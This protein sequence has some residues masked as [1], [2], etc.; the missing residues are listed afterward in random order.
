MRNIL[1]R[2]T[3]HYI[4]I[5]YQGYNLQAS[6]KTLVLKFEPAVRNKNK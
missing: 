4:G 6:K 3:G 2:D 1:L 5:C